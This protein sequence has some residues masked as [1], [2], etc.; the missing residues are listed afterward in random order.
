MII[1]IDIQGKKKKYNM[2]D[3]WL[4]VSLSN[5]QRFLA[6]QDLNPSSAATNTINL[7]SDIPKEVI[8]QLSLTDV[9]ALLSQIN[10]M[11][12]EKDAK[13]RATFILE[14]TKYGFI[15]SLEDISLGEYADIETFIKGGVEDNLSNI[16]SVLFRPIVKES[17]HGYTIEAYDGATQKSRSKL[18]NYMSAVQVQNSLVFFWSFGNLLSKAFRLS[19]IVKMQK[20][21]KK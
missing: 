10:E 9:V 21:E 3:S 18:F 8:K 7:F 11:E 2:I 6:Y 12:F 5:L 1:N 4:D 14:G 20:K 19:L 16:M 17:K 15:P 13:H